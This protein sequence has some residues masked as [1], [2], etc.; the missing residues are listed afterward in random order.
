MAGGLVGGG[1]ETG[2][3]PP[4]SSPLRRD[5]AFAVHGEVLQNLPA[6]RLPDNGSKGDG[7]GQIRTASP[8]LILPFSVL[9][10]LG[11]IMLAVMEIK[12]G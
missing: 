10:P 12:E 6:I 5:K 11:V 1:G 7:D 8:V 4:P 2:I 9:T 3:P